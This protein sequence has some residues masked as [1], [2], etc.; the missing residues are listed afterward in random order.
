[1]AERPRGLAAV[2]A[3]ARGPSA[4]EVVTVTVAVAVAV[5]VTVTVT[6]PGLGFRACRAS[7]LRFQ[8]L[9]FRV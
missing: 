7:G 9:G 5:A 2:A 8:V 3:L 1:M 6:V 4:Q